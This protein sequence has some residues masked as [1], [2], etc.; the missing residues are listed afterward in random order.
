MK[1]VRKIL[2][3]LMGLSML[4]GCSSMPPSAQP[5]TPIVHQSESE[6]ISQPVTISEETIQQE[7]AVEENIKLSTVRLEIDGESITLSD[8]LVF[9]LDNGSII[10]FDESTPIFEYLYSSSLNGEIKLGPIRE[11]R[12][13]ENTVMVSQRLNQWEEFYGIGT[14]ETSTEKRKYAITTMYADNTYLTEIGELGITALIQDYL[15][16]AV[17]DKVNDPQNFI[18]EGAS[19][20][21]GHASQ[22]EKKFIEYNQNIVIEYKGQALL[23]RE[24]FDGLSEI[25]VTPNHLTLTFA[26]GDVFSIYLDSQFMGEKNSLIEV[27]NGEVGSEWS[28]I[29]FTGG[30]YNGQVICYAKH[31]SDGT[32]AT[33]VPESSSEK[34]N[35]DLKSLIEKLSIK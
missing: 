12:T 32:I 33:V 10:T 15:P 22:E 29:T 30:D 34:H 8:K 35:I 19:I 26:T 9:P 28:K 11:N 13:T 24:N 4:A 2:A 20:L 16:K 5:P 6:T 14:E 18:D 17:W 27:K 25:C 1:R 31:L 23:N 7:D 21:L 3:I